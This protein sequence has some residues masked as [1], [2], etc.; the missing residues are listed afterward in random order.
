MSKSN[1]KDI[2]SSL[3]MSKHDK[4][5]LM[6]LLNKV[7]NSESSGGGIQIVDS[8]EKLNTLNV[9]VGS[10][11]AVAVPGAIK[12]SSFR[13]LYQP[14]EADVD[15]E[16]MIIHTER[17]SLVKSI[18]VTLP[19]DTSAFPERP[20]L[21]MLAPRDFKMETNTKMLIITVNQNTCTAILEPT[22][23]G[24]MFNLVDFTNGI[25]NNDEVDAFNQLLAS[26]DWC[27]AGDTQD[28]LVTQEEYDILDQVIKAV[29][30]VPST[31]SI[32]LKK[33]NWEEL[34]EKQ[35]KELTSIINNVKDNLESKADI[36]NIN[37]I[38]GRTEKIKPNTYYKAE[39]GNTLSFTYKLITPTGDLK[40]AEYILE[41][42]CKSTPSSVTFQ[43]DNSENLNIKWSNGVEPVF[44]NGKTYL[45][46]IVDNLGVFTFFINE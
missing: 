3:V 4:S 12:E 35:F 20:L 19:T 6:Q 17:F 31:A 27:Y 33:D 21:I 8:E 24:R 15:L 13:D 45:I 1:I 38:Y 29:A 18:N 26:E 39:I 40:Y 11:A 37:K 43:N 9:P 42:N 32:Y 14:T 44:E 5:N 16:N 41:L 30:G 22:T 2:I 7:E 23:D 28:F 25:I 36:I 10:L 34:N 46:S